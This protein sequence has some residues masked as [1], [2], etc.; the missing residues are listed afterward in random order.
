MDGINGLDLSNETP[1]VF[2]FAECYMYDRHPRIKL[3]AASVRLELLL[4]SRVLKTDGGGIDKKIDF[5]VTKRS[6]S[7][8]WN[9]ERIILGEE[10]P[11]RA[12]DLQ[13]PR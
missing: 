2:Y 4:A 1:I 8:Y 13:A 6:D 9:L 3:S 7:F 12:R 11:A 5:Q 10:T